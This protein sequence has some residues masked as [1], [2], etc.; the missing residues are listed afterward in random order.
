M[1]SKAAIWTDIKEQE[2]RIGENLERPEIAR[3]VNY[4]YNKF[5]SGS[6]WPADDISGASGYMPTMKAYGDGRRKSGTSHGRIPTSPV[7]ER[8]SGATER[9]GFK[10]SL[11]AEKHHPLKPLIFKHLDGRRDSAVSVFFG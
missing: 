9:T 1:K 10:W 8:G 5:T 6:K 11:R 2:R 4:I 7:G 3:L